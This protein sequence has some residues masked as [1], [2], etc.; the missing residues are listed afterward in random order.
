MNSKIFKFVNYL[1]VMMIT[2]I[3]A[4]IYLAVGIFSFTLVPVIFTVVQTMYSLMEEEIDGYTGIFKYFNTVFFENLKK[5]KKEEL[6]TGIYVLILVIAIII[7]RRIELPIATIINM[8]FMY[9]YA[10]ISVYLA[11]YKLVSLI[12]NDKIKHIDTL[13]LIFRSSKNLI[14]TILIFIISIIIGIMFKEFLVL[15]SIS[16]FTLLLIKINKRTL[17]Y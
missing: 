11:Y 15:F 4:L 17:N 6:F 10:V 8:L 1:Y 9:I 5:Y 13:R 12:K 14:K 3:M 2:N 7:L 16:L